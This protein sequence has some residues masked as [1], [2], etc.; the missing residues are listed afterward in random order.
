MPTIELQGQTIE[1]SVR[2]S[3]RAKRISLRFDVERGFQIVYPLGPKQAS[4]EEVFMQKRAWVLKALQKLRAYQN[5]KPFTRS[6]KQGAIFPY[7]GENLTLCLIEWEN[8][9]KVSV[10]EMKNRLE[11]KLPLAFMDDTRLIQSAIENFYRQRAKYYL[12]P[13]AQE[14]AVIHGFVFNNIRIKNQKTLWGSCS[15]KRNLNFNMRLMMTPPGA[16]DSVIIHELCHLRELNHSKSFW[17]M[18]EKHSPD[19]RKWDQ[20]FKENERY[21]VF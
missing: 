3:Q 18:L 10:Q 4:P 14:L 21:L 20:W 6:Y 19:Y 12:P 15:G 9:E 13:R 11:V 5:H 7:L 16:I 2:K 1:Y 8:Q 17:E